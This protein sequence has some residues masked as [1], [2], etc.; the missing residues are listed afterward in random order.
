MLDIKYIQNNLDEIK[1]VCKR[2]NVEVDVDR[3]V[4]VYMQLNK[5]R[6]ETDALKNKKNKANDQVNVL[7]KK[8]ERAD[9][10]IS[11][12][13]AANKCIADNDAEIAKLGKEYNA[14]LL[15]V[16]NILHRDVKDENKVV[17]E[18]GE[19]PKYDFKPL[20]HWEIC[21]K[22]GLVD[23]ANGIKL[24]GERGY[25]LTGKGARIVRALRD[26][27]LDVHKEYEEILPPLFVNHE[28]LEKTGFFPGGEKEVYETEDGKVFVG[29]AEIPLIARF[30][31]KN[32]DKLPVRMKAFTPCFRREA[33]KHGIDTRGI[34]RLH[35]FEKIELVTIA[36]EETA[37]ALFEEK[38][39]CIERIYQ[40]LK[41]PYRIVELAANDCAKKEYFAKDIE[42]WFEAEQKW[43]ELGTIAHC[44]AYAARRAGMK[45]VDN[46][47]GEKK[48]C[49]T[50]YGTGGV[51]I[52]LLIAL[53][54]NCQNKDGTITLPEILVPY[55]GMERIE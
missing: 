27:I 9:D 22:L 17:K 7:R 54:N 36:D 53:L 40:L 29:T 1:N 20:P 25:F 6:V 31:G 10:L 12:I 21:E 41:L 42:V 39:A 19:K 26:F 28:I 49:R 51:P 33:G 55:A 4:E 13:K 16:P 43:A 44:D 34:F 11:E 46:K 48:H 38:I 47:T 18:A 30:A 23:F 3:L 5:L 45:Y 32:F 14:L 2:R 35:Q 52:R 15:Q 8:A 50:I 24:A 37:F